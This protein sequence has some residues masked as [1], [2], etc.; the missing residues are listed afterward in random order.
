MDQNQQQALTKVFAGYRV[1]E[2]GFSRVVFPADE[3]NLV[4]KYTITSSAMKELDALKALKS[5]DHVIK[6]IGEPSRMLLEGIDMVRFAMPRMNG[7]LTALVQ[8]GVLTEVL[9]RRITKQL[10]SGMYEMHTHNVAHLDL[11][12]DNV[13]Y[14]GL[15]DSKTGGL[16]DVRVSYAD[17]GLSAVNV[18]SATMMTGVRGSTAYVAPEM[19]K[20]EPWSPFAADTY[21]F[22]VMIYALFY[23]CF[24]FEAASLVNSKYKKFDI[25]LSLTA[26][27]PTNALDG[28]WPSLTLSAAPG[29]LR[30]IFDSCLQIDPAKRFRFHER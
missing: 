17:F 15:V 24:P 25:A 5:C 18:T 27:T 20:K 1:V 30:E 16:E 3:K 9:R 2:G 4:Y 13:L 8:S 21:S 11:K 26:Q 7:D 6:V 22:G 29:W 12:L 23:V 19:W 10:I 14:F 28:L